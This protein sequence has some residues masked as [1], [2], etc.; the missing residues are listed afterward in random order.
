MVHNDELL[1]MSDQKYNEFLPHFESWK[2][3]DIVIWITNLDKNR[4]GKYS[5]KLLNNMNK[6]GIDGIKLSQLI[7]DDIYALGITDFMDIKHLMK[8]INRLCS[9]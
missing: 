2:A 4:Y 9:N 5:D 3:Q 6:K 8:C 1:D 7:E